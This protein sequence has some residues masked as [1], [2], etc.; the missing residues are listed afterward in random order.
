[1]MFED[2]WNAR[3]RVPA[4]ADKALDAALT[5]SPAFAKELEKS[6]KAVRESAR[7]LDDD[8]L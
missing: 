4:S 8:E 3:T 6:L 5:R 2:L 1:M 7:P